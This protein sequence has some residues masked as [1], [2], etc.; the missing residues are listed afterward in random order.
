MDNIP[1]D[2]LTPTQLDL[3][4]EEPLTEDQQ[5][6]EWSAQSTQGISWKVYNGDALQTLK[7]LD[8]E[9]FDCVVTSPPYYWLR[10]YKVE[11]QLGQE[12]TVIEYVESL[13][14]VMDEVFRVLKKSGVLFLNIGDTYYSGKGEPQ[15][16]DLKSSKRRFGIR[17]VDKSGGLG[18]G[19]RAK[20]AIGIPWR[21]AI[22]MAQRQ[23]VLRSPIVWHRKHALPEHVTDRPRRTY[24]YVFMFVKNRKYHFDRQPLIDAEVE[25]MWTITA[26]PEPT[27]GIDTAPFPDELVERCL[28]IGCPA[29]GAVLDPF[30]GSATT[31]R[32]AIKSKRPATGIDLNPDFCRFMVKQ[33]KKL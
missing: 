2:A 12:E 29:G 32:V 8:T 25:D 33:L 26:R 7:K 22:E 11:G 10:D 3:Q 18:I 6:R 9:I 1:Y 13:C 21:V 14:S 17:A 19:L 31:L 24:E 4:I 5:V 23:W 28:A 30:A 16:P 15:G 20:T 27:N